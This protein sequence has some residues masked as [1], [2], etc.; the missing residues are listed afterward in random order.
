MKERAPGA[1]PGRR[2]FHRA[3]LALALSPWIARAQPGGDESPH[4]AIYMYDG[5]DRDARI[6]SEAKK[7]G[8]VVIGLLG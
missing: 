3:A 7:Q 1:R 4:R 6:A 5:K 2:R 8:T